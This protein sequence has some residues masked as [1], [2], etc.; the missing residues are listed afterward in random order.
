MTTYCESCSAADC[1]C[2]MNDP[3]CE[4]ENCIE[5]HNTDD[6]SCDSCGEIR[7]ENGIVWAEAC[8]E[9]MD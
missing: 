3:P 8:A 6:C 2:Y 4:C 7:R 1:E 5:N 9:A